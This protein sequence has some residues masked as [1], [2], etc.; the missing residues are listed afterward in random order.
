MG[1]QDE[2]TSKAYSL[3]VDLAH[4]LKFSNIRRD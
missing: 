3:Q 4:K 1:D 2:S